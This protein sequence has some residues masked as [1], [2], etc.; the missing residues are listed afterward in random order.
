MSNDS[1]IG[2]R[3]TATTG[4]FTSRVA[5][6]NSS[7]R[8]FDAAA[9]SAKVAT[10]DAADGMGG[11]SLA[12]SG[13]STELIR[14]GHEAISGNFSRMP[15][16]LLVL[17]S[18][19]GGLSLATVGIGA[20]I[21]AVGY[22]LYEFANRANEAAGEVNKLNVALDMTGKSGYVNGEALGAEIDR[23]SSLPG[24][25]RKAAEGVVNDFSHAQNIGGDMILKLT[26]ITNDFGSAVGMNFEKAGSE[27]QKVF[28][29]IGR[30][31]Q[32]LENMFNGQLNP[33][34]VNAAINLANAGHT[35]EAQ[36][37][38]YA[39]LQAKVKDATD[40]GLTPMAAVIKKTGEYFSEATA[41]VEKFLGPITRV[42]SALAHLPTTMM[43]G[44]DP[45]DLADDTKQLEAQA[46]A[47]AKKSAIE[48]KNNSALSTALEL[49]RSIGG[50]TKKLVDLNNELAKLK[51]GE[52]KGTAA[53]TA[54]ILASERS[55]YQQI[56]DLRNADVQKEAAAEAEKRSLIEEDYQDFVTKQELMVEKGNQTRGQMYEALISE[57]QKEEIAI[58]ASFDK[59]LALYNRQ[60]K[61]YQKMKDDELRAEQ[62]FQNE[63][64]KLRLQKQQADDKADKKF[65][66]DF[67]KSLQQV[68]SA[69]TKSFT[70]M[71]AGSRTWQQGFQS[72]ARSAFASFIQYTL[73]AGEKYIATEILKAAASKSGALASAAAWLVSLLEGTTASKADAIGQIAAD[74]AVA[75]AGA[76]AAIAAIPYVGPA[77]APA[78]AATAYAG[79]ISYEGLVGA[80]AGAWSV[81]EGAY[82]LHDDE[83]VLPKGQAEKFRENAANNAL[84]GGGGSSHVHFHVS[85]MDGKDVAKFFQKNGKTIADTLKN[86]VR[87]M[88][89]HA[90]LART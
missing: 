38:L 67:V 68:N 25:T 74:A 57:K 59:E 39:E 69:F 89:A 27:L 33:S 6:L 83:A 54:Q 77:L 23:L 12:T 13:V 40:N 55:V 22:T 20:A 41:A 90:T 19:M 71:L 49:S 52:G 76:Y 65:T 63:L 84:G 51:A 11:L 31:G 78:A 34:V 50:E 81:K 86:H 5:E 87:S 44:M 2:V 10:L 37:L 18:R 61:A 14:L 60:S 32:S 8:E 42:A 64:D 66:D 80:E 58:E 53:D 21:A 17:T 30:N 24:V 16:S 28:S 85:A 62:K 36:N 75:G 7:F 26:N 35:V 72:I 70:D 1:E 3:F 46:D 48:A 4:D 15:G 45:T 73:Q 43:E 82:H 9:N 88:G 47:T 29:D 56:A 79:A